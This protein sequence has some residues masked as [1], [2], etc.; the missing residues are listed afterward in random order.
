[1]NIPYKKIGD[2]IVLFL[3]YQMKKFIRNFFEKLRIKHNCNYIKQNRKKV[4]QRVKK[5]VNSRPLKV[6]FYI[7]DNTKWKCQ[8]LYELME[9]DKHF[10]PLIVVTKNCAPQSN[11]NYQNLFEINKTYNF[12]KNKKMNVELAYDIKNDKFIPLKEF[13]PDIIFYQHPFY[14]ETSQGPVVCSEFALT[15]YVP[16]F[17]ATSEGENEYYLR[18]HQYIETHYVLNDFIKKT[19]S[20]KMPNKGKNLKAVGHPQLDY[21]YLK[22]FQEKNNEEYIIYAPHWT[23]DNNNLLKWG[24]FAWNGEFILEY[25]KQHPEKKWIFKPHPCFRENLK[26][27]YSTNFAEK[28]FKEWEGIGQICETGDYLDLF[29]Q[30][31]VLITDCGSFLTEYFMTGK[32]VIHLCS[33]RAIEYNAS[34]KKIISTYYRVWNQSDLAKTLDEVVVKNKDYLEEKR[35]IALKELQLKDNYAAKNILNDIKSELRINE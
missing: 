10:N 24:T 19:F 2:T 25:A 16:Y 31:K 29:I 12:F 27:I 28:Y 5:I 7:Y 34:V 3:P 32:P 30:S 35:I 26:R 13:N 33:E 1:M 11:F 14:V 15:Y 6:I 20:Q 18:F 9:Q 17:I 4:L 22:K 8:S 21:F 23:I